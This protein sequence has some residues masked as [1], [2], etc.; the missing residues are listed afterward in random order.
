MKKTTYHIT[1]AANTNLQRA[2]GGV[3]N[4]WNESQTIELT[5][6]VHEIRS[7]E[8]RFFLDI[9]ETVPDNVMA[10]LLFHF[11]TEG[12]LLDEEGIRI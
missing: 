11:R 3:V 9:E 2:R 5:M 7:L 12:M 1:V 10:D 8:R 4:V 6:T